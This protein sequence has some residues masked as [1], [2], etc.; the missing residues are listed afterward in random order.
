MK[1]FLALYG[2][3][4]RE[5]LRD[6]TS[7]V[8][9]LVMPIVLAAFFGLIFARTPTFQLDLALVREDPGPGGAAIAR[10]LQQPSLRDT[11]AVH[12]LS[13]DQALKWL[14]DGKVAVALILPA[15]LTHGLGAGQPQRLE[16]YYD[17][18]RPMQ[19]GPGLSL[20]RQ[21]LG[22]ANLSLAHAPALLT[23]D[24]HA[25]ATQ[26]VPKSQEFLPG[27]LALAILWL[28]VFATAPPLMKLREQQILRRLR[29]TPVSAGTVMTAQVAWRLTIG[30]IQA[31]AIVL[32]GMN[33]FH[34][35]PQASWS[36]LPVV[37]LLGTAVFVVL[38]ILL[39][40]L[41]PGSE[42]LGTM[43]QL[44]QFPMMFLSGIF[45][46]MEMLPGFLR[47]VTDAIPL[48]YLADALRQ[49]MVGMP[50]LHAL[51]LDLA[52]LGGWLVVL[53]ALA[54]RFFRWD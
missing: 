4:A 53:G 19:V 30:A 27:M 10:A 17:P 35:Q 28:G 38:G 52:V 23:L 14:R 12:E 7:F 1:A 21:V 51:S 37:V 26:T 18:G 49:T 29:L 32:L 46:P 15:S 8:L 9:T 6:R 33:A 34:L 39:A 2:A 20:L 50:P 54:W 40:G 43:G 5:Y 24:E 31:V 42:A 13:R 41:A 47:P 16:A 3:T 48:T 45:F 25:T 11:L 44:V 22:Q 36:L